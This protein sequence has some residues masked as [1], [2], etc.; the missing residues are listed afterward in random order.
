MPWNAFCF[1][2]STFLF[3][4]Q[5][6]QKYSFGFTLACKSVWILTFSVFKYFPYNFKIII[7]Q[8][9]L[10]IKFFFLKVLLFFLPKVQ[11]ALCA[12]AVC[13]KSV[14]VVWRP[15]LQRSV[16]QLSNNCYCLCK[17]CKQRNNHAHK[18]VNSGTQNCANNKEI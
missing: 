10:L 9:Y 5:R 11:S 7:L 4:I 3:K 12:D 1:R 6:K 13:L 2:R 18:V 16:E 8:I 14:I 17:G 15:P